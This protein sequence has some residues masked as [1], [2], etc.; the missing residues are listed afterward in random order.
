M[1]EQA[2]YELV[3]DAVREAVRGEQGGADVALHKRLVAGEVAFRDAEGKVVKTI[4]TEVVFRKL[5]AI[6]EKLRVMEQKINNHPALAEEDK[7]ELQA[8]LSRAYGSMTTFNFL[9]RDEEDKFKGTG[10]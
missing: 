8:Y 1:D 9:F 10:G 7:V 4:P 6:R 2:L 3:V 5:T